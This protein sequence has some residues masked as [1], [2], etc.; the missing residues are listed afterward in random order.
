MGLGKTTLV[1]D[2]ITQTKGRVEYYAPTHAL[3]A[4]VQARLQE[5]NPALSVHVVAGRSHPGPNG[6]PL[7]AKHK[8]AEDVA[9]A[10]GEVYASLCRREKSKTVE[11]CSHY[12]T[13]PYIAQFGPADVTIYPHA[14]LPL[15]RMKLEPGVPDVAVIDESFYS[16]CIEVV[17]VPIRLLRA[18]FLEPP[19]ARLCGTVE[20]ALVQGLPVFGHLLKTGLDGMDCI[21]ALKSLRRGRGGVTPKMSIPDQHAAVAQIRE[22]TLLRTLLWTLIAEHG[23]RED[24]QALTYDPVNQLIKVHIKKP[25]PRFH[26]RTFGAP[27]KSARVLIIDGSANEL[28]IK[29]WFPDLRMTAIAAPRNARVVQCCTTRCST[30]SLVPKRNTDPASKKAARKRLRQL[31]AFVLRTAGQFKKVLVVGPQAITGNPRA[32]VKPLLRVP[33]NVELA[34]FNAVRG[35]DKWKDHDAIILVGRNEPPIEAVEEIARCVFFEART[36]LRFAKEWTVEARGYRL[37]GGKRGVQVVRHPDS[38]VQAIVE[39]LREGE[40]LQAIDRLRLVHA[41]SPKTVYILSNIPLDIDVDALVTWDELMQGSRLEQAWNALPGVMPLSPE[42][43]TKRFPRLWKTTDAAKADVRRGAKE[44]QLTN[45]IYISNL[46]LFKH[47]YRPA[48]LLGRGPRQRAWSTFLSRDVDPERARVGLEELIGCA[49]EL[50]Q[51]KPASRPSATIQPVAPL[52]VIAASS[53]T[54]VIAPN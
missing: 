53:S 6:K 10:G 47:Q 28:I 49:L 27:G 29:Q 7:C 5:Q 42:W 51:S 22:R 31:Q 44:C 18:P 40:S 19:T 11:Q 41:T 16:S 26:E 15:Q 50:R 2:A 54:S 3:A 8:L 39:Q 38:R 30:T 33:P 52:P 12:A 48:R 32:K 21:A 13:S 45:R 14:Y 1:V 35:I 43:L 34:H 17:E 24:S 36:P 20:Q 25:M 23:R 4:E 46:T 9:R 37:K